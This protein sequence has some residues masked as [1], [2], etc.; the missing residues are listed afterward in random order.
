MSYAKIEL[1]EPKVQF[2]LAVEVSFSAKNAYKFPS[3]SVQRYL[4]W[5]P[6][7]APCP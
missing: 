4:R 2:S 5:A 6:I 1:A 3:L 7:G